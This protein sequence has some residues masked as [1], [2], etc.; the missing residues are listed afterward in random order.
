MVSQSV[1]IGS[2][3]AGAT[4][5]TLCAGAVL[6]YLCCYRKKNKYTFSR[7]HPVQKDPN[8]ISITPDSI[9]PGLLTSM[10]TD[11]DPSMTSSSSHAYPPHVSPRKHQGAIKVRPGER[12]PQREHTDGSPGKKEHS[13]E[14]SSSQTSQTAGGHVSTQLFKGK[15][16]SQE[17]GLGK[18]E[19]QFTRYGGTLPR[20]TDAIEEEDDV[21]DGEPAPASDD[22]V[23]EAVTVHSLSYSSASSME[24]R[25]DIMASHP[26]PKHTS[27]SSMDS[28]TG[29]LARLSM[30]GSDSRPWMEG[31]SKR[32][33]LQKSLTLLSM[34]AGSARRVQDAPLG[35]VL[36]R[37]E[38]VFGVVIDDT[39][40]TLQ[41]HL[42][43]A[44]GLPGKT[45]ST[46]VKGFLV[47]MRNIS[48]QGEV[49]SH[50]ASWKSKKVMKT[51]EPAFEST[52]T[53]PC[54]PIAD[55]NHLGLLMYIYDHNQLAKD[56]VI[57]HVWMPLKDIDIHAKQTMWKAMKQGK[58]LSSEECQVPLGELKLAVGYSRGSRKLAVTIRKAR[59]LQKTRLAKPPDPFVK[60]R[61]VYNDY[62]IASLEMEQQ[63]HTT[64]PTFNETVHFTLDPDVDIQ[65]CTLTVV[66]WHYEQLGSNIPIGIINLS[67]MER[68][69]KAQQHWRQI[70]SG[71]GEMVEKDHKLQPYST[72]APYSKKKKRAKVERR[73]DMN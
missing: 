43:C 47:N 29:S 35:Q 40:D 57:G 44:E 46:F 41:V 30:L 68:S 50:E 15:R 22:I 14:Q 60:V 23:L 27:A 1:I 8:R 64:D 31:E 34:D 66:V 13:G 51:C 25:S 3:A 59:D 71:N 55:F 17:G 39:P 5:A 36:F 70:M 42:H 37:I 38:K 2:A 26:R 32:S 52:H 33:S 4:F 7:F 20:Q 18:Q 6:Y 19:G 72:V 10:L 69:G 73:V 24:S 49:L 63:Q 67:A 11:H 48:A 9:K 12:R 58:L 65:R 56:D 21:F 16:N 62:K 61:L 54:P 45:P 28:T 53:M